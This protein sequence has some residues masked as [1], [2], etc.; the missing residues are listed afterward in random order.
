MSKNITITLSDAEYKALSVVAV[1]PEEWVENAAKSRASV[2]LEE[3]FSAEVER[4]LAVGKPITG[5]KDDIV[6]AAEVETAFER[7]ERQ[8]SEVL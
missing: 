2:S 7:Q 8:N 5:T 1:S 4:L 3:I 6:L